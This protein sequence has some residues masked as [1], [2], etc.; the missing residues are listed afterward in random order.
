M[1]SSKDDNFIM[2]GKIR[3][4]SPEEKEKRRRQILSSAIEVFDSVGFINASMSAISKHS[5][6]SRTLINFYFND[7]RSLHKELEI[8]SLRMIEDLMIENINSIK[9]PLRKLKLCA[10]S[11]V[12]FNQKHRGLYECLVRDDDEIGIGP[13]LKNNSKKISDIVVSVLKEGVKERSLKNP[14]ESYDKAAIGIWSIAH[15]HAVIYENK[16]EILEDYWNISNKHKF[17]SI[18]LIIESLFSTHMLSGQKDM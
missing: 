14:Y 10:H 6:L 13:I 4:R 11:F 3:C 8:Y 16:K 5:G 12:Q 15:G 2:T 1:L 9:S 7:K 18:D 17:K